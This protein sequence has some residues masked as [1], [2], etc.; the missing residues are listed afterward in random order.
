M[1]V[2]VPT[3]ASLLGG[4]IRRIDH[5]DDAAELLQWVD[6]NAM[7][8]PPVAGGAPVN[9]ALEGAPAEAGAGIAAVAA[10][11]VEQLQ[12]AFAHRFPLTSAQDQAEEALQKIKQKSKICDHNRSYNRKMLRSAKNPNLDQAPLELKR[13]LRELTGWRTS[14]RLR[15]GTIT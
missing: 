10:A 9:V 3:C 11:T 13:S 6:M 4:L 2:H 15:S 12:R 14:S 7:P 5:T 8:V 1:L